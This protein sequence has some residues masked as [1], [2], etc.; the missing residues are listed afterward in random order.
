[1]LPKLINSQADGQASCKQAQAVFQTD[2]GCVWYQNLLPI[3]S[4]AIKDNLV[5]NVLTAAEL[6]RQ[7]RERDR[8]RQKRS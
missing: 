1:M 6:W 3:C 8:Q 7:C 5:S 2:L 4:I